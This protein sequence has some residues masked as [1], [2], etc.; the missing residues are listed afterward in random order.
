[1]A[2]SPHFLP[3][4]VKIPVSRFP[5]HLYLKERIFYYRF[6]VPKTFPFGKA[7]IRFS[8]HTPYKNQAAK[9]A[10]SVHSLVLSILEISQ[11]IARKDFTITAVRPIIKQAV[12]DEIK[13]MLAEPDK[14]PISIAEARK[15]IN[16]YLR[17]VLDQDL[18][19]KNP[20]PLIGEDELSIDS[21]Y[22]D[23]CAEL[24]RDNGEEAL[25]LKEALEREKSAYDTN[26]NVLDIIFKLGEGLK[27]S[28]NT[29]ENFDDYYFGQL[30]D[31]LRHDVLKP[32]EITAE[33]AHGIA[34]AM[35]IMKSHYI[36]VL[37]ARWHG[38]YTFE[39]QF[40]HE[41]FIPY[42]DSDKQNAQ[43][44]IPANEHLKL[45]DLIDKYISTNI[46][47]GNWQTRTISDHRNRLKPLLFIIGDKPC[48]EY[49]REDI[50]LLR[51]KL[52]LLPPRWNKKLSTS[53]QTIDNL[54]ADNK[55]CPTLSPKTINTII[56]AVSSMFSWAINEGLLASNPAR[57]LSIKDSQAPID[58]KLPLSG[59][60][61]KKIF[62]AGDYRIDNFKKAAFYWC[63]LISLY[64]GMRLEEICQLH[65]E[66]IYQDGGIYIIDIREQSNDG[67]NDKILK[68]RNATRKIPIHPQLIK[69]GLI[70]YV[71]AQKRNHR[72][73]LFTELNKT[74]RS[75]KYGKQ[76][77]KQFSV[78]LKRKGI[79]GNKSFH[80]L[81]HSFSNFF[82]KRNLHTDMF[83]QV[84]GHEIPGLAGRQYGDRFTPKEIYDQLIVKIDFENSDL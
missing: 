36:D 41:D 69:S 64:T 24:S 3:V 59:E 77:G 73:R 15:K 34:K 70:D 74:E 20:S 51:E 5:S 54:I 35:M 11:K 79:T 2:A 66:D 56:E 67:L 29:L 57:N 13:A 83:R 72:I 58:K 47:D 75:P 37:K 48:N 71:A 8:L 62:F 82:K 39:K 30:S 68:T 6:R 9:M 42:L 14:H 16:G 23:A 26:Q 21:Q 43:I 63:P 17:F 38:D 10:E 65:C 44:P 55:N 1:M 4:Q 22:E 53:G 28:V 60:E 78:L 19:S 18:A 31:L 49:T 40:Y 7:E 25:E 84:F 46:E 80:S 76:V 52:K 81:R 50:R 32:Q 27:E 33:N 61:I 12:K 45:S